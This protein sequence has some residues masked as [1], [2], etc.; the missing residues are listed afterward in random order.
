MNCVSPWYNRNGWLDVKN[1]L[2]TGKPAIWMYPRLESPSCQFDPT[3]YNYLI[4]CS[5]VWSCRCFCLIYFCFWTIFLTSFPLNLRLLK[6]RLFCVALGCCFS[7]YEM[8]ILVGGMCN[9]IYVAIWHMAL[10]IYIVFLICDC[11]CPFV[12]YIFLKI[13]SWNARSKWYHSGANGTS[14]F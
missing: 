12:F 6:G 4:S 13:W 9:T 5:S 2:P 8:S 1:Q 10:C 7:G 11:F 14:I 3:F